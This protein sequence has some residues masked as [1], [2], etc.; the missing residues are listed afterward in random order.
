MGLL[1]KSLKQFKQESGDRVNLRVVLKIGIEMIQRLRY[2][3]DMGFV[4]KDL[5][6]ANIMF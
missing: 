4:H 3:H 6:P 1:G 5:K 2:L